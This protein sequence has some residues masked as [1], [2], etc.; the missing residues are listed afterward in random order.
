[1]A[2]ILRSNDPPAPSFDQFSYALSGHTP[3]NGTIFC[4]TPFRF[5]FIDI[6]STRISFPPFCF[7][8]VTLL[9]GVSK[10]S[11]L[12]SFPSWR[13]HDRPLFTLPPSTESNRLSPPRQFH[14]F[15]FFWTLIHSSMPRY[16]ITV[17]FPH[18]PPPALKG[19][20]FFF[21]SSPPSLLI[22][23]TIYTEFKGFSNSPPMA[24]LAITCE[25]P[26]DYSLF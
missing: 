4:S 24:E 16:A 10:V 13:N 5:F 9:S 8:L 23:G 7:T 12:V 11:L 1:M 14:L 15:F 26:L 3:T 6:D 2:L 22:Q 18:F 17:P 19:E 20:E 25:L 21:R